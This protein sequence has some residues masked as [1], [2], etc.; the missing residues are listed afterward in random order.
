MSGVSEGLEESSDDGAGV[1]KRPVMARERVKSLFASLTRRK[2][3]YDTNLGDEGPAPKDHYHLI[4]ICAL[5]GGVG[6]LIPWSC[7]IGAVD[8]FF[9]YYNTICTS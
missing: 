6:F 2:A 9:Y 4:Y 7:F 1:R 5:M 8:Y 3:S